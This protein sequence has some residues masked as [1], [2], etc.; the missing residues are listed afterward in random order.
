MELISPGL[1]LISLGMEHISLTMEHISPG[2]IGNLF[3]NG[4]IFFM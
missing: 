4:G 2:N 1:E 3:F